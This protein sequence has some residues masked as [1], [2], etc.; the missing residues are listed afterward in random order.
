[1]APEIVGTSSIL[2]IVEVVTHT[3]IIVGN[4][5]NWEILLVGM[6]ERVYNSFEGCSVPMYDCFFTG[7]GLHIPFSDFEVAVINHLKVPPPQQLHPRAWAF[8]MAFHIYV[9]YKSW[10]PS[11]GL[12]LNLFFVAHTLLNDAQD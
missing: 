9:S 2:N 7:L 12:F 3:N 10:K 6:D 1:M 8:M 5:P 11:L 4:S